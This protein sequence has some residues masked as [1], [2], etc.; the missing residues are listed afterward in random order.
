ME[1]MPKVLIVDPNDPFRQTLKSLLV[2][3]FPAMVFEE[4]IDAE[5]ALKKINDFIPNL[6]LTDIR[7]PGLSGLYLTEK[8]KD[9]YPNSIVVILTSF[10]SEEYRKAALQQGS[11][12]FVSKDT[13]TAEKILALIESIMEKHF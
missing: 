13:S 2:S 6:I 1:P 3:R 10:D 4:A 7:L 8:I 11:N 9:S 12:Y 5:D